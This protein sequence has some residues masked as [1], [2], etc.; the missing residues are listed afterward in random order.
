MITI[1]YNLSST[2]LA[3]H[4]A[5]SRGIDRNDSGRPAADCATKSTHNGLRP[6]QP[7]WIVIG[8]GKGHLIRST[9]MNTW[10]LTDNQY[11]YGLNRRFDKRIRQ[12]F[13]FGFIQYDAA[14]PQMHG[15]NASWTGHFVNPA[16]NHYSTKYGIQPLHRYHI[17]HMSKRCWFRAL[18][19]H[20][21]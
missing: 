13:R 9:T 12:M 15:I 2:L 16:S 8:P 1:Q 7:T 6:G 17:M 21:A 10:D 20:M 14:K 18:K 3:S 11:F 19:D 4:P 5:Q